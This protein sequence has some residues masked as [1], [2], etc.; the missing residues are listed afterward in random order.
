YYPVLAR[1]LFQTA[2]ELNRETG[3]HIA[4][5]NLSGGIGIPYRP[6]QKPADGERIPTL[7]ELL[8]L[9]RAHGANVRLNL[10]TKITPTSGDEV[11]PPAEFARLVLEAIDRANLQDRVTIQS[12]D[13]RTLIEVKRLRPQQPTA[14]LTIESPSMDTV[15]GHA[16]EGSP[17]HAGLKGSSLPALVKAAGCETWSM[18]WRNLTPARAAEAKALGLKLLPWTVNEEADMARLIDLGVDGIITDYPDRLRRVMAAKG[19]ARP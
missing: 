6:E 2:V 3:A 5:I 1:I 9:V 16:Q 18:F 4:F 11:P 17:W 13:W 19:L 8:A 12:F 15:R 10:E 7:A 14:C